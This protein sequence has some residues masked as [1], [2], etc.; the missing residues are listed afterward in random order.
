MQKKPEEGDSAPPLFAASVETRVLGNGPAVPG[1]SARGT[2]R[3]V[4]CAPTLMEVCR[5][6]AV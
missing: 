1:R 2:N 4:V 6:P 3:V 5:R